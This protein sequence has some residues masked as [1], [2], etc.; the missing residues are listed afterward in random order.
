MNTVEPI[1]DKQKIKAMKAILKSGSLRNYLLFTLGI[2]AGLRVSDLLKLKIS[3][4]SNGK[5][6]DFIHIRAKKTGKE[7][8][9][10]LSKTVKDAIKEYITSL[11]EYNPDWYLFKSRE[12]ENKPISRVHAYDILN[13]AANLCGINEKIGTH[14]LRKT[15]AYHARMDGTDISLLQKLFGHSSP[16][17]TM[18]YIGIT[19]DEI[20]DVYL[21]SNL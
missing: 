13:D 7:T 20:Q 21:N 2:N 4:V 17:I 10:S 12:G 11:G 1:R 3:D 8:K 19:D 14:T 5:I 9:F 16:S 6:K 15:F 18:R